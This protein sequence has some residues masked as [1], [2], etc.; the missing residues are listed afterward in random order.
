MSKM[1]PR[2][3]PVPELVRGL[4]VRRLIALVPAA[5]LVLALTSASPA[6]AVAN[7]AMASA[8][9][10][11]GCSVS[12]QLP[13]W[14]NGADGHIDKATWKCSGVPTTITLSGFV[15]LQR[16]FYLWLCPSEPRDNILWLAQHCRTAW[17]NHENL[18][19]TPR[20]K[21]GTRTV[22]PA[23]AKGA[24]GTGWYIGY[25]LWQS[26]GPHGAGKNITTYGPAKHLTG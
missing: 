7:R 4:R 18:K 25:I 14:S 3:W 26:H 20:H 17:S 11:N 1:T 21:S 10:A 6:S 2:D 9:D 24:R 12:I 19:L 5:G 16:G 8:A 23:P 13:H 22:P 15:V